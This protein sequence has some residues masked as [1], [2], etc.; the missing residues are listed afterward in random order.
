MH[1]LTYKIP[2]RISKYHQHFS[3][4]QIEKLNK[5]NEMILRNHHPEC[6]MNYIPDLL[7][8]PS[9]VICAVLINLKFYKFPT[10]PP[11]SR[12]GLVFDQPTQ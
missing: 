11:V 2:R 7:S 12:R 4:C 6:T 5:N 3:I 8:M 10:T 9:L 1:I